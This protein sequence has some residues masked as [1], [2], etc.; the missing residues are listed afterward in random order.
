MSAAG[1]F[2]VV[3][4][5]SFPNDLIAVLGRR[6]ASDGSPLGDDFALATYTGGNQ[7]WP[8]VDIDAA[9]NFV[10]A[11]SSQ[12]FE[13]QCGDDDRESIRARRFDSNGIGQG[14]EF[15]VNS[16]T[17]DRQERPRIAFVNTSAPGAEEVSGGFVIVWESGYY[18]VGEPDGSYSA[19]RG[20]AFTNSGS[21]VGGEFQVNSYTTNR[22][23]YPD[24]A[25]Q[26]DGRFAVV[27]HSIG[28][29]DTDDS[30]HSSQ[31]QRFLAS[32]IFAGTFESG[33]SS[34]WTVFP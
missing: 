27:W 6:F 19:I 32:Y 14:S 21:T 20:Q 4:G 11:F 3:W 29:S 22:Q 17:T 28:S 13:P 31:G 25:A 30:I 8:S 12:C 34:G 5:G 15:L 16:Y 7:N 33:D 18:G 26:P 24:I 23:Q 10:V 9:G 1:D 2:V